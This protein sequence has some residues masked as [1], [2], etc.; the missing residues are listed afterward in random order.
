MDDSGPPAD[1]GQDEGPAAW[2]AAILAAR[3]IPP[4]TRKNLT[5]KLAHRVDSAKSVARTPSSAL[6]PPAP[7]PPAKPTQ[8][9]AAPAD[10]ST[11]ADRQAA[12]SSARRPQPKHAPHRQGQGARF[13]QEARR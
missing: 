13:R 1:R 9:G 6:N 2:L 12:D 3:W 10:A 5:E 4:K 8:N 7:A 11:P